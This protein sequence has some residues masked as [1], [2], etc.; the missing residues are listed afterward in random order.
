MDKSPFL[1]NGGRLHPR[2]QRGRFSSQLKTITPNVNKTGR[3]IKFQLQPYNNHENL[4]VAPD[5]TYELSKQSPEMPTMGNYQYPR[6][7]ISKRTQN[8]AVEPILINRGLPTNDGQIN[9]RSPNY[10]SEL[11]KISF[12]SPSRKIFPVDR[13]TKIYNIRDSTL[14]SEHKSPEFSLSPVTRYDRTQNENDENNPSNVRNID[15]ATPSQSDNPTSNKHIVSEIKTVQG[16]GSHLMCYWCAI[17]IENER[18]LESSGPNHMSV[19]TEDIE[20]KSNSDGQQISLN[21]RDSNTKFI[22]KDKNDDS[23]S[24]NDLPSTVSEEFHRNIPQEA[25]T[26]SNNFLSSFNKIFNNR[27]RKPTDAAEEGPFFDPNHEVDKESINIGVTAATDVLK[28]FQFRPNL[29]NLL[30]SNLPTYLKK[31]SSVHG[32]YPSSLSASDKDKSPGALSLATNAVH[33]LHS[34]PLHSYLSSADPVL[35]KSLQSNLFEIRGPE[36]LLSSTHKETPEELMT[37]ITRSKAKLKSR[38][39][40]IHR[41]LLLDAWWRLRLFLHVGHGQPW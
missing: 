30:S 37:E 28:P 12:S 2:N 11:Q 26:R 5:K 25:I 16:T 33:L 19:G 7:T 8:L 20:F 32:L 10:K 35:Q 40:H 21:N 22:Q 3:N 31:L 4:N 24:H 23:S 15:S 41:S 39:P 9:L 13:G 6:T 34:P 18:T 27:Q 38:Q 29:A 17:R 36:H 1:L 14:S